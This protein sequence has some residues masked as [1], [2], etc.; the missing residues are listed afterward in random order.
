MEENA[1]AKLLREWGLG[2][3][4]PHIILAGSWV[5]GV[6]ALTSIAAIAWWKGAYVI[7]TL[8]ILLGT[9]QFIHTP[10][11]WPAFGQ[12]LKDCNGRLYYKSC[13]LE[14]HPDMAKKKTM[15]CYHPHGILPCGFSWNGVHCN[16][17][18]VYEVE[19]VV[20]SALFMLPI[21]SILILCIGNISNATTQT[22]KK[23][24]ESEK[25]VALLPGGFEDATVM[26]YGKERIFLANRKGFVK[27]ALRYGYR[28]QP[29]YTFGESQTYLTCSWFTDFRLWLNKFKIP[30]PLVFGDPL[31]P[32]MPRS[33]A[34]LAT[35]V[36]DPIQFPTISQPTNAD[37]DEWHATYVKG[38]RALFDAKKAHAG[39]PDAVLEIV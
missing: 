14:L 4:T 32:F 30:L 27:F 8:T 33:K 15:L 39:Y 38:L 2:G 19:W 1:L 7:A 29:I 21:F 31:A 3:V 35:Y 18:K 6:P 23:L 36:G 10:A 17:F 5:L 37:V 13:T 16:E 20:A 11:K 9:V 12:F 24:M 34:S 26:Q 22:L 28:V 25:N